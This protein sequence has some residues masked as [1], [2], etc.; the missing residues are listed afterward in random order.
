MGS[1]I[2]LLPAF[3]QT[4]INYVALAT[5]LKGYV[6]FGGPESKYGGD[7][8]A[9]TYVQSILTILVAEILSQ[10]VYESSRRRYL[11]QGF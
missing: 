3:L 9:M 1:A 7:L 5:G 11:P 10:L 8:G 2:E 4:V 6:S